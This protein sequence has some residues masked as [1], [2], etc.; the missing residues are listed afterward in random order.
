MVE[1]YDKENEFTLVPNPHYRGEKPKLD[2]IRFKVAPDAQARLLALQ[3]G[4]V[5][6]VGG[7]LVG[8]IPLESI[9]Q[10]MADPS[11]E[12]VTQGTLCSH[13]IAFNNDNGK[14]SDKNLRLAINYAVD[15]KVIAEHLF[16][17][18]GQE[19]QGLYR[20]GVPYVTIQNSYGYPGDK[21]KARHILDQ[22]GYLDNG[23][24]V[25]EKD[26]QKLEYRFV[27]SASEFPEW[28][29]L[30][31]YVQYELAQVGIKINLHILDQ[32]GY[33]ET[34]LWN[35]MFDMAF[36]RTASDSWMPHSSLLELFAPFPTPDRPAKV[37]TDAHLLDLITTTLTT[38]DP[39][40][41]QQKYDQVFGYISEQALCVPLY[42]PITSFAYNPDRVK[43]FEIGV[44]NYA[45]L[46]WQKLEVVSEE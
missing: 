24:G 20:P 39:Q 35:R 2:R 38:L 15:K 41:R 16:D 3:S 5:D 32:N 22:A 37:W 28:K 30:A 25:R 29:A 10:L 7:D 43:H 21:E 18:V 40:E 26:G 19:A 23:D 12:V 36:M 33:T 6:I 1:S 27:L 44:N 34:T 42:Y 31:E 9:P 45:P 46:A 13:L 8:K 17:N 4:E 14:F 11:L